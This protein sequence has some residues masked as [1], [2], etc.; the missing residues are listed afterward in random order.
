MK[1]LCLCLGLIAVLW[2]PA[3]VFAFGMEMALG[4]WYQSPSGTLSY[5][6]D[7][8]LDLEN[9]LF[10]DQE[11]SFQGRL[12]LDMPLMLPNIY[13]MVSSMK[14]DEIGKTNR[15]FKFGEKVFFA[16][17]YFDSTLRLHSIDCALYYGIPFIKTFTADKLN[18]EIGLNARVYDVKT[19]I[20]QE[21]SRLSESREYVLTIPM[22]YLAASV[23]PLKVLAIEAEARGIS[24]S[25]DHFYSFLGRIR[26]NPWGPLFF[27][28]GYRFDD[29]IFD[30][31]EVDV[32]ASFQGPFAEIGFEF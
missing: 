32:N 31:R 27:A 2:M 26:I 9:E 17:A 15:N 18:V 25:G 6:S 14:F 13:I 22:V 16:N 21:A 19:E 11:V 20:L 3:D 30:E 23:R 24:Y 29:V 8:N 5:Q 28:G 7:E 12:K 4:S 10:Y 1:K